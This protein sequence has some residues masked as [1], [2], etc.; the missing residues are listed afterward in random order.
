MNRAFVSLIVITGLMAVAEGPVAAHHSYSAFEMQQDKTIAGT[1]KKFDWTNPH[2]WL[3]I[4]VPNEQG[5]ADTWG[6]EGMSPNY[7]ARRGW[8]K[9]TLK[10]GDKITVV[11][12]PLRDGSHGGSFQR[13]TL[14]NGQTMSM[15]G[16]PTE[17]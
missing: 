16:Q 8:T 6:I 13:V 11:I 9:S 17:P 4:D 14:P 15:T 7:L 1:V 3:W 5:A 12:H 10:F 2:T